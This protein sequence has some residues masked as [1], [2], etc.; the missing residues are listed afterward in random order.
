LLALPWSKRTDDVLSISAASRVLDEH[1]Y[2][3]PKV[4]E[5]ILEYLA[6]RELQPTG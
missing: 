4:K 2:G 3:L 6:V 5:R 1:H